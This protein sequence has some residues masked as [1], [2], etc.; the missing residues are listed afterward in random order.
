M[1][2]NLDQNRLTPDQE[3][4]LL[5]C[6][7]TLASY[8]EDA[9]EAGRAYQTI[10]D[11][12]LYRPEYATFPEYCGHKWDRSRAH[13]DRLIAAARVQSLLTPIGVKLLNEYQAR[14]L[15]FLLDDEIK[16][17][18]KLLLHIASARE[19]T[20]EDCRQVAAKIRTSRSVVS[21]R[22]K[23]S[24]MRKIAE[25]VLAHVSAADK[26]LKQGEAKAVLA[27][28]AHLRDYL[29]GI[30][31]KHGAGDKAVIANSSTSAAAPAE[32]PGVPPGGG[33]RVLAT[34]KTFSEGS[35][36]NLP[37]NTEDS[38]GASQPSPESEVGTVKTHS[39]PVPPVKPEKCGCRPVAV[40]LGPSGGA[41]TKWNEVPLFVA[42]LLL[43]EGPIRP[44]VPFIRRQASEFP[45][46]AR[47]K[48]LDDG[49][50]IE[51][52]D[53]RAN[54]LRKTRRLLENS[55]RGHQ[56]LAIQ[57]SDGTSFEV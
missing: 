21:A 6:E 1:D 53:D 37:E 47:L 50:L 42:N 4:S 33:C 24:K 49:W 31:A 23:L 35:P 48:P 19:I 54:L 27:A 55:G 34:R 18:G 44:D 2:E 40:V 36:E 7:S 11:Q 20:A 14:K 8:E 41:I 46:S 28:L 57:L 16:E 51:L 30:A 9:F 22:P 56:K 17:A 25:E 3:R 32:T 13:V 39:N 43:K 12:R 15:S 26:A 45:P 29:E 38:D 52:G 10:R 5:K